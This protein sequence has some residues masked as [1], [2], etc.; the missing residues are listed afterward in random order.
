MLLK[1]IIHKYIYQK[2]IPIETKFSIKFKWKQALET[3]ETI[4]NLMASRRH[5]V[6]LF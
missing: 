1:I 5:A 2:I 4:E 6:A 3:E